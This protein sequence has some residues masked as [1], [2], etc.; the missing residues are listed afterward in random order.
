MPIRAIALLVLCSAVACGGAVTSAGGLADAG[1]DAAPGTEG[2]TLVDASSPSDAAADAQR[3][4]GCP[5]SLPQAGSPCTPTSPPGG[6]QL[7]CEYAG[8]PHCTTLAYC[9][10]AG[11]GSGFTW[12]ITGPDPSCGG[13]PSSC[14]AAFGAAP[15]Q[16]C[17]S[18]ETCTYAQ[19][20]C[21]CINCVTDAG[22]QSTGWTCA[23]WQTPAGC[24]EPAPLLG[25]A[26]STEGQQ[27]NYGPVCCG[28]SGLGYPMVCQGGYWT[29]VG[30]G[31]DCAEPLCGG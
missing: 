30:G 11:P 13:N 15:G 12:Q 18:S 23:A 24:P 14:P 21:E 31:C 22:A 7:L 20:R 17:P 10:G 1:A 6:G 8:Q 9:A 2:G 19:G 27:C 4:P 25:T 28:P 29:V 3:A 16:A 26:C 5:S